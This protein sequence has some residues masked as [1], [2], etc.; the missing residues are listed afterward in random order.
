MEG[1]IR[2][3]TVAPEGCEVTEVEEGLF[4]VDAAPFVWSFFLGAE[5]TLECERPRVVVSM[6]PGFKVIF[7]A[8][9]P[10]RS[11]ASAERMGRALV[12]GVTNAMTGV[13][14]TEASAL[15]S[16]GE[17]ERPGTCREIDHEFEGMSL[18]TATCAVWQTAPSG[19]EHIGVVSLTNTREEWA[20]MAGDAVHMAGRVFDRW[21]VAETTD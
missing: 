6:G 2:V 11:E 5:P 20:R 18:R 12:D 8:V 16:V 1:P 19:L 17:R 15:L 13:E 10:S 3:T 4:R 14:P 7:V 9:D 21:I